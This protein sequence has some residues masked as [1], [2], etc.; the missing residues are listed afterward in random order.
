MSSGTAGY[1]P[2]QL[3]SNS[4]TRSE[5]ENSGPNACDTL[6]SRR[7][8][9]S[10][11]L[12]HRVRRELKSGGFSHALEGAELLELA[13]QAAVDQKSFDV[14]ALNMTSVINFTDYFLVV[15]GTSPRHAQGI[16]DKVISRLKLSGAAPVSVTGYDQGEW[17]VVDYSDIV[18]HVFHEP[19]R[20]YYEFDELWKQAAPV[21]MEPELEK[22][23]RHLRT[24][25]FR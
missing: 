8:G 14:R 25:R 17:I 19:T 9:N 10:N 7:G 23:V 24:G 5:Q 1:S 18:V 20:Q 16:A 12:D 15:S 3:S 21:D 6:S 4:D 11:D 13:I 22:Q 2:S